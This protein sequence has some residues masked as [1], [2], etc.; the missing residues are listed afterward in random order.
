MSIASDDLIYL[1]N[2]ATT[3]VH[4]RA[5]DAM[6]PFF[7]QQFGNPASLHQ[8]GAAVA[9]RIDE[10]RCTIAASIGAR[11]S[12]IVFTS[13]G[14]E[15]NNLAL[16]GVMRARPS[17]KRLIL[18]T[19]EHHAILEP[20]EQ[21]AREGFDVVRI[22]VDAAGRP[23]IPA[24]AAACTPETAL[25]S[26]MLANNETGVLMPVPEVARM[27]KSAGALLHT[28][29]V[30][31]L[32]KL[33]IAVDPLGADLLSLSAH[34]IHGPKGV[35]ALYVR[36]GTPLQPQILGGPQERNRRGGTSNAAGI[37]GFAAACAIFDFADNER[38]AALRNR[39]EQ[40]IL[41]RCPRV[42]VIGRATQR[43]GNTSCLCFE[44]AAS[45]PILLL[46]SEAGVC[47]SSGA[48][49]SSG[50]LEPSHVLAAMGIDP[51][52][53]QGQIRFSLSRF[54]T[55]AEVDRVIRIL[56]G[57]VERVASVSTL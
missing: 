7:T 51:A 15:A 3:A 4:P 2:N 43:V 34:K 16:R 47:A 5:L 41:A 39:L 18:S 38:I 44:G 40:E 20:A 8:F 1:D 53:A 13:G 25:I 29:A 32:G 52:I 45:E 14:T 42:H 36:R 49:C 33:P 26:I 17:R 57:I 22:G 48:A 6:L 46:L 50:S 19:V 35:G 31:A 12:E 55:D 23:D 28:D 30:N 10:A 11:E 27:A 54:T 37:V 24:L 56:P 9:A 21:L